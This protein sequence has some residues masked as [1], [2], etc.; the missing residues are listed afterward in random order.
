MS[1]PLSRMMSWDRAFSWPSP[2]LG[3]A[4]LYA[5]SLACTT[6]ASRLVCPHSLQISNIFIV[7]H[8]S[9][10]G[11]HA[12]YLMEGNSPRVEQRVASCSAMRSSSPLLHTC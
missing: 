12:L 11:T 2:M 1:K 4:S 9:L 5:P 8:H 10:A 7:S 3:S 6:S